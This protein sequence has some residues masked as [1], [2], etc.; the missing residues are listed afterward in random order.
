MFYWPVESGGSLMIEQTAA[1][2]SKRILVQ[3]FW[4]SSDGTSGPWLKNRL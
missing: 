4:V 3:Q 2:I 1:L